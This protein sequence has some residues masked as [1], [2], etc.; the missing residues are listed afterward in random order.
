M[1]NSNNKPI[2]NEVKGSNRLVSIVMTIECVII[3]VAYVAEFLKGDRSPQYAFGTA[4]FDACI[5]ITCWILYKI[6]PDHKLIRHVMGVGFPLF[7]IFVLFTTENTLTFTY[8]IPIL[9]IAS[10][11]ADAKFALLESI[12]FIACNIG[13]IIYFFVKGIY[14]SEN[15]AFMEI[16]FF[17]VI[18]IAGSAYFSVHRVEMNNRERERR[19]QNEASR[20]KDILDKTM[21]VTRETNQNIEI[22]GQSIDSL[23]KSIKRTSD[24]M[25][26]VDSGALNTTETVQAQMQLTEDI[27]NKLATV[28]ENYNEIHNNLGGTLAAVHEG[29]GTITELAEKSAETIEKGNTV[30]AKLTNLNT[31]MER[32]NSAVDI[33]STITTKTNLLSLN[34]SIEA[35]RAGEAG[36]GFAVVA[37]EIQKMAGNTKD[38]T[39]QI[40]QMVEDVSTAIGDVVT[41]TTEMINQI[42]VQAETTEAT[43]TS[44]EKIEKNT[45]SI[46]ECANAMSVAMDSLTRSTA[47]ISESI[48]TIAA[49]SE[50]VAT[51]ANETLYSCDDNLKTVVAIQSSMKN[52]SELAASLNQ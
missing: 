44:F 35:A 32:M 26:T 52:L 39:T 46:K 13:Q 42:M 11:Y 10:A 30:N 5:P 19:I 29:K 3:A 22:V 8:A 18:L 48:S 17:I 50:E 7:Y 43:V 23:E 49:I 40:Q 12:G 2:D 15:T 38:A 28:A 24:A 14:N 1:D 21:V 36:R 31:I 6:R 41:V 4:L 25:K 47:E 33:I 27:Q 34:A 9:L 45:D 37:T 51:N 16:H 20:T